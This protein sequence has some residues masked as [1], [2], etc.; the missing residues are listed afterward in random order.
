M[1]KMAT[2]ITSDTE[3]ALQ[4]AALLSDTLPFGSCRVFFRHPAV[5]QL[6]CDGE[7]NVKVSNLYVSNLILRMY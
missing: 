5:W 2:R 7:I 3:L 4:H 6:S 1:L